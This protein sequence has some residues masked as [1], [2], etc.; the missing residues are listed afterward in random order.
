VDEIY[1]GLITPLYD[2][3]T[4]KTKNGRTCSVQAIERDR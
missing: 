4:F 3:M 2:D 1:K